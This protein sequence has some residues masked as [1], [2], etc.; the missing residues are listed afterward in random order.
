MT[1]HQ[2]VPS[3]GEALEVGCRFAFRDT[4]E[5]GVVESRYAAEGEHGL[6]S[7][8]VGGLD[9][10]EVERL[11]RSSVRPVRRDLRP[12]ISRTRFSVRPSHEDRDVSDGRLPEEGVEWDIAAE[13]LV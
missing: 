9:R 2:P 13:V 11:I 7:G 3:D 4:V 8:E 6:T 1:S 12:L 5:L 10:R